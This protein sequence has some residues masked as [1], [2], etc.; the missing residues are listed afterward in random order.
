MEL[1]FKNLTEIKGGLSNKLVFRKSANK[2]SK[3]IIDF[4]K[5]EKKFWNFLNIYEILKKINVSIPKIY[6]VYLQK[7]IIV[8]E[9]FGDN[10]FDKIVNEKDLYYLL[11]LAI[12]NLI[13]IQN[14]IIEENL[15]KLEKYTF[16]NLKNEISELVDYYIPFK[17]VPDF[18]IDDFY[19]LWEKVYSSNNFDFNYFSH[20][21]YEFINLIFI[22][23]NKYHLKCGI[24]DFED[25]FLGFKGW[26]LF[27]IL[28]NPR[29]ELT[30]DY[31]E[32][33]IKYFYNNTTNITE[34]HIFRKHYYILNLA[35]QTRLLGRWVKILNEGKIEFLN[36]I[37]PTKNR[38]IS[39]LINIEVTELKKIY[40]KFVI[41]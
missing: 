27:S 36:Y 9:D 39:C 7:K 2:C 3:I 34:F 11:K 40:E 12:D 14:S 23:K 15:L 19:N 22:N 4:S 41:N 35:R 1:F 29:L 33:L 6:E 16:K 24:I 18:P 32:N 30:R 13:I 38:I 28:E 5:D 21:D 20:K 25:A 17:K 26:D 31:N 8:M 37:K 10:K